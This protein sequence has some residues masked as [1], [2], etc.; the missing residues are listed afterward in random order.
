MASGTNSE[1]EQVVLAL[2]AFV[3]LANALC[4]GLEVFLHL[5][6]VTMSANLLQG[7]LLLQ[8][9]CGVVNLE[10]IDGIFVVETILVHADNGLYAAVDASLSTGRSLLDTHLWQTCLDG[11]CHTAQLLDF[12]DVL[13]SLVIQLVGELLNI[14][15][16]GPRV[17]V[18]AD[19]RLVLDVDLRVTSDTS[20]EVCRQGDGFV[21]GVGVQ[22]LG[23]TK[24]GSHSL[25]TGTTH[26][27]EGILLCQRP[28]GRLRVCA[29]SHR[30]G[31]LRTE[32]LYN[33]GPQQAA[34]T[35]LCD[36]HEVVHTDSP[37]EREARCEGIH[38]DACIDTCTQ[39]VH[40]VGQRVS[41]LDV[42]CCACFLHVVA[43]DGDAV[44]LRHLLRG[45]FEDVGDDLH[46][47]CWRV[48]VG[49]TH[50]EL[51][52][53]VV[54]DGTCH[55]L[56]FR[57]L[58]K[59][60]IDVEGQDGQHGTIH[61]HG[62]GHLIQG[63]A[64][65]QDLHVLQR[66]DAHACLTY[67]AY[68]TL[69]VGVIATVCGK[70]ERYGQTFLTGSEVTAIECIGLFCR[71]EASVLTNSP[72]TE[73]IHHAVRATKE[74]RNTCCE[75]QVFH[76]LEVFLSINGLNVNLLG[77]LPVGSDTILF[78]P[79]MAV[80]GLD[81]GKDVYVV[82]LFSHFV[83]FLMEHKDTKT[84]RIIDTKITSL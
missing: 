76:A 45:I 36:F 59:A 56:Q 15:R 49:V 2:L 75:V 70:V 47:E 11:L 62:D 72:R 9:H 48:D 14:V 33:L 22:R 54:L 66:A 83:L 53:D 28:T 4:D 78:L 60:C 79:G 17:D 43:R 10:D 39:V 57:A 69:V 13:P 77:C 24:H 3:K 1:V 82:E 74:R 6:L 65:E 63:N 30:L 7:F 27:V 50:H 37:E 73:G 81:A 51:L 21:E 34:C 32:A 55:L 31:V 71:R 68:D 38:V 61:R 80:L 46:G 8:T 84:Q 67:I 12:L 18:L 41:Q 16:A 19:L 42:G 20:R 40:T 44:E 25:D 64:V 58:L 35:H 52:Q 26:I 5:S 23:V 29:E